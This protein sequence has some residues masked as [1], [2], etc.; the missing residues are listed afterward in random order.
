MTLNNIEVIFRVLGIPA[1]DLRDHERQKTGA[2][3]GSDEDEPATKRN[4][5]EGN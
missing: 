4:K 5:P 3:S 2:K 1:E